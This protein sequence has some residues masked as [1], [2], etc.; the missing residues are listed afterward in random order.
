MFT[1]FPNDYSCI[2]FLVTLLITILAILTFALTLHN[3][4]KE[5]LK[6]DTV[7]LKPNNYKVI[8]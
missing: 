2:G 6:M 5:R 8:M 3:M 7:Y 4:D 1:A